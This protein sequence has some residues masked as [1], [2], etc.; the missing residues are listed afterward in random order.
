MLIDVKQYVS[1]FWGGLAAIGWWGATVFWPT[2]QVEGRHHG[3]SRSPPNQYPASPQTHGREENRE[4][5][6]NT[7][8]GEIFVS[9]DNIFKNTDIPD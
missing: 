1:V 7:K 4:K 2:N 8:T 9:E 6:K 3:R 5:H